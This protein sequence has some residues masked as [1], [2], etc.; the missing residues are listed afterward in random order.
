MRTR[1]TTTKNCQ[2]CGTPFE[3][4]DR[5]AKLCPGR[6]VQAHEAEYSRRARASWTEER[7]RASVMTGCA[8][9]SGKLVRQPCEV[10]GKRDSVAHHDDYAQ[11][12]DIR[13]LCRSHHKQHHLKFGPGLNAFAQ[14]SIGAKS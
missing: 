7:R 11:P 9:A 8:I 3:A 14:P 13:W 2:R 10:C 6:C 12:L 4:R 5:R 1:K